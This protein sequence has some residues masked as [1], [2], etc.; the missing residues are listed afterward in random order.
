MRTYVLLRCTIPEVL[1]STNYL[2]GVVLKNHRLSER[3]LYSFVSFYY[4]LFYSGSP[5]GDWRTR[6]RTTD[7]YTKHCFFSPVPS[8][9]KQQNSYSVVYT[10]FYTEV[11]DKVPKIYSD[12]CHQVGRI[13][14][15]RLSTK[16]DRGLIYVWFTT[17]K[18]TLWSY[19]EGVRNGG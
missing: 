10:E 7:K 6:N 19:E 2:G 3:V 11:L 4:S 18:R 9:H 13:S 1:L 12:D 15:S 14:V 16:R 5:C 8:S 17:R